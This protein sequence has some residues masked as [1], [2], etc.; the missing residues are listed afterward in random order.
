MIPNFRGSLPLT[1]SSYLLSLHFSRLLLTSTYILAFFIAG[2]II[3]TNIMDTTIP[4]SEV[5]KFN[6][7]HNYI[8]NENYLSFSNSLQTKSIS[9][10]IIFS[11]KSNSIP[12]ALYSCGKDFEEPSDNASLYFSMA[13][14]GSFL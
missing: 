9:S 13:I 5:I 7:N 10:F 2:T 12:I 3:G 14:L 4:I 1:Y 11:E 6:K 8:L